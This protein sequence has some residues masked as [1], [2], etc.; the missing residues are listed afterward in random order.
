[1]KK[2]LIG[3][4][5]FICSFFTSIYSQDLAP[6]LKY[7]IKKAQQ[8]NHTN[9]VYQHEINQA[10]IDERLAK[11]VFLPKISVSGSYTKL[12]S[13]ISFDDSMKNMLFGL[14]K[15]LIKEKIGIPFNAP[16]PKKGIPLKEIPNIQDENVLKSS[17]DL[18]WIIF[19]GFKVTNA[20]RASKHKQ[21]AVQYKE[22]A[23]KDKV[24]LKIIES[25]NKLALVLAS[26]KVLTSTEKYLDGQRNFVNNAVKNG[27][28]TPI[29]RKKIELAQQQLATKQLEAKNKKALII[30]LLH[31]LTNEDKIFLNNLSPSLQLFNTKIENKSQKRNEIKALEKAQKATVYQAKMEKSNFIPK[32]AVKGH[33]EFIDK[34][35]TML[36][37]KWYVAVGAKWNIFNG[38]QSNLK[39]QKALLE[40]EKYSEQLANAKELIELSIIKASLEL[41]SANQTI[42]MVQKEVAL[43]NSTLEM[44]NK[45]YKNN[46]TTINEVLQ[47]L[48]EVEKA[49]FK[50]QKSY[51]KQY[52]A[53]INLLYAK[54]NLNY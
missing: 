18:D 28:A 43:A 38:N 45:Q 32:I 29:E 41:Q 48:N 24:A 4:G 2:F 47:A 21:E 16:F 50:L 14:Q 34:N 19:S 49:N 39:A 7:L 20:V 36:D 13:P 27:L 17:A 9:K 25:Y 22:M 33:Y 12:D 6:N 35:L 8:K 37:P 44:L 26:E 31:Q 10:K 15:V 42:T 54:G 5:I 23:N 40:S 46:L 3:I 52:E 51:Y 53:G 1:M 11:S 30:E